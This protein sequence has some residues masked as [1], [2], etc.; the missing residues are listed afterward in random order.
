MAMD[1]A[2]RVEAHRTQARTGSGEFSSF[3]SSRKAHGKA[4]NTKQQG[5]M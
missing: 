5:E 1:A 2:Y 4:R 3:G